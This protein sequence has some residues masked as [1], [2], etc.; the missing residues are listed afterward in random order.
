MPGLCELIAL[1]DRTDLF[2]GPWT[3][4]VYMLDVN[5]GNISFGD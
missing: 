2:V 1:M 5:P 3:F 4:G